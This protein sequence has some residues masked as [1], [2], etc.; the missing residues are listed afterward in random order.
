[1]H[2]PN[3]FNMFLTDRRYQRF[4][5][6]LYDLIIFNYFCF[7]PFVVAEG[8]ESAALYLL[9]KKEREKCTLFDGYLARC[10]FSQL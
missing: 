8:R 10:K 5:R 6:I 2:H 4:G 7:G 3:F 9:L 1:M